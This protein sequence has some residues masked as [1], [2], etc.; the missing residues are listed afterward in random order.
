MA[1][2]TPDPEEPD[3][4]LCKVCTHDPCFIHCQICGG[5]GILTLSKIRNLDTGEDIE[6][7]KAQH[8]SCYR[9][10]V[11]TVWATAMLLSQT[12]SGI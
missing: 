12:G 4:V 10:P 5:S 6:I 1:Y 2:G 8:V 7:A 3:S 9:C 11:G